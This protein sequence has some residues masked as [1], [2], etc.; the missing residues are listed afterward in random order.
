MLCCKGYADGRLLP[1][2]HLPQWSKLF[3]YGLI[4]L[5]KN[6][7]QISYHIYGLNVSKI[8]GFPG[9][10]FLVGCLVRMADYEAIK[11]PFMVLN[12]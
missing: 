10:N 12:C 3:F 7:F 11:L 9:C 1:V 5:K 2:I 4:C 8:D 6:S